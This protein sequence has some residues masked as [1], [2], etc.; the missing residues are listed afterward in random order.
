MLGRK[1][2]RRESREQYLHRLERTAT[3]LP[4]NFID[5]SVGDMARQCKR[6]HDAQGGYFE[7]GGKGQ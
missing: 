2:S 3:R 4:R 1:S 5:G 6:L 7:E